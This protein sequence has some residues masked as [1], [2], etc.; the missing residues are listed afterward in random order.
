MIA[1]IAAAKGSRKES[2]NQSMGNRINNATI[3]D[4]ILTI[5]I[6]SQKLNTA[7]ASGSLTVSLDRQIDVF[8]LHI[9][10]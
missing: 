9:G 2:E 1:T 3:A 4:I 5:I 7:K 8:G 10:P 6:T